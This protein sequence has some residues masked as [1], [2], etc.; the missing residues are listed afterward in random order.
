M[1]VTSDSVVVTLEA[2]IDGYNRDINQAADNTSRKLDQITGST[3]KMG[4]AGTDAFALLRGAAVGFAASVGVDALARVIK[5]GLDYAAGLKNIAQAAGVSSQF[6]QEFRFAATASGATIEQADAGLAKFSKSLGDAFNGKSKEAVAN[7]TAALV[8]TGVSLQQ[9][10]KMTDSARFEAIS[11]GLSKIKDPAQAGTRALAL[12]GEANRALIPTLTAGGAAFRKA[13]LDAQSFGLILSDSQIAHADETA[14]KIQRLTQ[15]LQV[16]IAGTVADNANAIGTLAN[17]LTNLAVWAVKAGQQ[18]IGFANI[19]RNQSFL[20]ALGTYKSADLLAA[21]TPKGNAVS[22]IRGAADAQRRLASAERQVGY[23][24]DSASNQSELV[25]AKR[26]AVDAVQ[27]AKDAVTAAKASLN[28]NAGNA[29]AGGSATV[30]PPKGPKGPKGKDPADIEREFNRALARA[31]EDYLREQE[32]M[33]ADIAIRAGIESDLAERQRLQSVEDVSLNKDYSQARKDTLIAAID[34]AASARQDSINQQKIEALAD[35]SA[36]IAV[37]SL[38]SQEDILKLQG[39]LATTQAKRRD[40]E[41]SI[42]ALKYEEERIQN[43]RVIDD[44]LASKEAKA[45]A[46]RRN[47]TLAQRQNLDIQTAEQNTMTPGESYLK[48]LRKDA[49]G[50]NEDFQ[51]VAVD[52]L[53]SLNDGIAD[54]ILSG[55]SLGEVFNSVVNQIVSG[56]LKIAIQQAIIKPLGESLF[57]GGGGGGGLLSG[58]GNFASK[59][60]GRASGGDVQGGQT[61]RVNETGIEGFQPA[62]SGKII[63]LGRM[64]T[65]VSGGGTSIV[66]S[67]TLDARGGVVTQDL[68]DYVNAQAGQAAIAGARGGAQIASRNYAKA[69]ARRL[70]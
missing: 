31:Q 70:A 7:V 64:P 25:A 28:P 46:R 35:E 52:G 22:A 37:G 61:Y 56:L 27:N 50:L 26:A 5:S 60:V 34:K 12:F 9:L 13:A 15:A 23:A 14:S 51:Q 66:Q 49:Q 57:S 45:D 29:T 40:I 44:T 63:P 2:K 42:I 41:L 47:E 43:Q 24:P 53:K 59:L 11:D 69:A 48:D 10:A 38:S 36:K 6:L 1:A 20:T 17:E 16:K 21:A 19:V 8:G 30:T 4:A 68:L 18:F 65:A 32:D 33:T 39:G 62:G 55:K 3:K 54:A 58:I 67:F